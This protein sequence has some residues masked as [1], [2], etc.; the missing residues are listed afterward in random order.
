M[1]SDP[2]KQTCPRQ[3][4]MESPITVINQKS[5]KDIS[6]NGR[7]YHHIRKYESQDGEVHYWV[8]SNSF[9]PTIPNSK[10]RIWVCY[11]RLTT[12][13]INGQQ[14]LKTPP[15]D[16]GNCDVNGIEQGQKWIKRIMQRVGTA[17]G[18]AFYSKSDML[19]ALHYR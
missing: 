15:T 6:Y 8:C 5:S 3:T 7:E 4:I 10:K 16:H 2:S 18:Y 11:S 12:I 13:F 19:V 14:V 1:C 17:N 9:G